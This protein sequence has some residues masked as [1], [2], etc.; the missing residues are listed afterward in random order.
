MNLP[1]EFLLSHAEMHI[2]DNQ[3]CIIITDDN[4][5]RMKLKQLNNSLKTIS[6]GI[7]P[8][9]TF[10]Q[11]KISYKQ[12]ACAIQLLSTIHLLSMMPQEYLQSRVFN[13]RITLF[14]NLFNKADLNGRVYDGKITNF[15][16]VTT[17]E[18]LSKL[19][20][21]YRSAVSESAYKQQC[22][23]YKRASVKNL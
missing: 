21:D 1:E 19:V 3:Q 7:G 22:R 18:M 2:D 10:M 8:P 5:A 17:A 6:K 4:D 23:K 13:P 9:F 14:Q 16:P 20:Q 15:D 12:Q 11:D